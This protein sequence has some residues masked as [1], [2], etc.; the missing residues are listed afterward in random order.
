MISLV[1]LGVWIF[2]YPLNKKMTQV[3]RNE[4]NVLRGE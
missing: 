4:L 2:G 1:A 3:M